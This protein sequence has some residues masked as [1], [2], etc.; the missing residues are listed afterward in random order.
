MRLADFIRENRAPIIREWELFARSLTP[1]SDGM[2]RLALRD[3]V[4][5]LLAFI[6]D[7]LETLQSKTEQ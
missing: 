5:D 7:D 4:E 3:H 2:S 6:A 1:A